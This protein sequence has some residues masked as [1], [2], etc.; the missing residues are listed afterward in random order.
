MFSGLQANAAENPLA[1]GNRRY[2]I[3]FDSAAG[4]LRL[5]E[6]DNT[7]N[8]VTMDGTGGNPLVT[9]DEWFKWEC[10]VP[11]GL[12][13][14]QVYINGILTTFVPTFFVNGGG[15]GTQI[16]VSSGSTGGAN[17][18]SYHDNFGVTI[19][20][21]AATKT[22]AAATMAADVAQINIPEG[23]RDY[24][25]ILPDGNPRLIGSALRLA[26]NNLFGTVTLQNQ[27]PAAPEALFNGLAEIV[28]TVF[29]K[30]VVGG[31]NT[32]NSGNVYIGFKAEDVSRASAI[33]AQLHS[34]I[35]RI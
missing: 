30:E 4:N 11:A 9:F 17:R 23:K 16:I 13:A 33:F 28:F 21:A 34:I 7:G 26:V 31:V 29:A 35:G 18:I 20:E 3:L 27:T 1:T 25:I 24:V 32:V 5:I 22:L 15:L 8:N 6:A 10:V 19:F 14:A 2:G 12:G